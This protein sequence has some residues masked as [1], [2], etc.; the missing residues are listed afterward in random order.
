MVRL[1]ITRHGET[2]QNV[3]GTIQSEEHGDVNEKGSE[4][5]S[6]LIKRL[7][8]ENIDLIVSSDILRCKITAEKILREIKI[9]VEYTELVREKHNGDWVGKDLKEIN[10]DDLGED[11]ETRKPPNGE[12]LQEVKKRSRKFLKALL[13]KYKKEDKTI[14]MISHGTFSKVL[15]GDLLGLS[16]YDSIFKLSIAHCSLTEIDIDKKYREGYQIKFINEKDF[17]KV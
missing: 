13:E 11:F 1:L 14:L 10:W 9:P 2:K 17:L 16:L 5:I 12:N 3:E 4:Q 8:E 7:K 6:K 15:I